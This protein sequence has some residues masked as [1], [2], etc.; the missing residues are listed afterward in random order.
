MSAQANKSPNNRSANNKPVKNKQDNTPKFNQTQRRDQQKPNHN[1][2]NNVDGQQPQRQHTNAKN[3]DVN[4]GNGNFINIAIEQYVE[5]INSFT[6]SMDA[7]EICNQLGV[8]SQ[9]H[10]TV[11][12]QS[13]LKFLDVLRGKAINKN[14]RDLLIYYDIGLSPVYSSTLRKSI[15]YIK[16]M[17]T[18]SAKHNNITEEFAR[19]VG[20]LAGVCL[21]FNELDVINASTGQ[22]IKNYRN[23]CE[24]YKSNEF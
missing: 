5:G 17:L 24:Q 21:Y 7:L 1:R 11:A 12:V 19:Y 23:L 14:E 22:N 10:W 2:P 6:L 4:D 15:A 20:L 13:A 3:I 16:W 8:K 9:N 18:A